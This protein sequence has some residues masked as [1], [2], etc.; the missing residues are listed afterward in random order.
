MWKRKATENHLKIFLLI[1]NNN[2][3]TL[4]PIILEHLTSLED[5]INKYFPERKI[6]NYDWI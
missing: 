3:S 4:V 6:V 5:K 2:I 1:P